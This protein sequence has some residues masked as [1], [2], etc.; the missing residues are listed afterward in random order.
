MSS[1]TKKQNFM[2]LK[3]GTKFT[4]LHAAR[5]EIQIANKDVKIELLQKK[6][7]QMYF[8][9]GKMACRAI[10]GLVLVDFLGYSN[11]AFSQEIPVTLAVKAI[12]GEAENQGFQGMLA[13]ACTIRNRGTLH[14]V[15]GLHSPRVLCCKY[16]HR[17]YKLA[18]RA[19]KL[20][21]H[22]DITHGATNWNN[23][24]REGDNYWTK[25]MKVVFIY[26]D[27]IFYKQ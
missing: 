6:L 18:Q 2:I 11:P 16:S 17:T 22:E 9:L 1:A 5:N 26:R 20:S 3:K 27:H 24:K 15:Y 12:I 23:T 8:S 13:V 14:G 7:G 19:W 21:K 10:L 4:V 25:K